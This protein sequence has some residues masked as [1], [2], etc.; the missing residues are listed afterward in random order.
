MVKHINF[1]DNILLLSMRI[2]MI[3]DMILLDADPDFFLE[4]TVDDVDFIDRTLAILLGNLIENKWLIE[5]EEQL[6]N[7]YKTEYQ[8]GELLSAL[9]AGQG[10]ISG[11]KFPVIHEKIDALKKQSL[12]RQKSIS[13]S[14][15]ESANPSDNR[16]VGSD[17]LIE[18]LKDFQ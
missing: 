12:V 14:L 17:E 11:V 8:F 5:R 2:R 13:E 3:Q 18:L 15:A 10:S 6:Y 4:M 9:D 7:L 1:E 16:V